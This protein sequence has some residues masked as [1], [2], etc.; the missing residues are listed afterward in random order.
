M[1]SVRVLTTWV[2]AMLLGLILFTTG[3]SVQTSRTRVQGLVVDA[4]GA[5][6]PNAT[7]TLSNV[8][9]GVN[10]VRKTSGTG[11]YVFDL[12]R[13]STIRFQPDPGPPAPARTFLVPPVWRPPVR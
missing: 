5:V 2:N 8:N 7:V 12:V 13:A 1:K 3:A 6:V 10:T 9:T 11:L 4:S